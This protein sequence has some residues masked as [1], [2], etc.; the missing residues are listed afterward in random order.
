MRIE[1]TPQG[2]WLP[3]IDLWLDPQDN[4]DTAWVSHGHGDH[5]QGIHCRVIGTPETLEIYRIRLGATPEFRTL[6]YGESV[7]HRGAR[8]TCY[9]ASHI[10]GAAQLLIE[11]RG[12]RLLYTGDIKLRPSLCGVETA[13]VRCERLII[14]STFALPIF[15]F[16]TREEARS[17]I[18]LFARECLDEGA[19]PVFLAY[20][21]GRGQEIVHVLCT[22][23]IPTA[24]HG[25]VA[26]FLPLYESRGFGCPG[27]EEYENKST[28]GK[29]LV[30]VPGFR[31]ILQASGKKIRI[32]YVSGWAALDNARGRTG[33]EVLIPY[34]DHADFEELLDLVGRTTAC[35]VDV[36]HGY[37]EPFARIL[38]RQGLIARASAL[39]AARARD[40]SEG[41]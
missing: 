4:C 11:W 32:A 16:L 35:E 2:I 17:R 24:V 9:P 23:G 8:L 20:P 27:W 28:Q 21:L 6:E 18:I 19:T 29:A 38:G 25:A 36:V 33:A 13:E 5:A 14:E 3:E 34:S 7:D 22:E 40:E 1:F 39:T 37:S 26:R 31:N 41:A 12:E 30:A 10:L 15:H